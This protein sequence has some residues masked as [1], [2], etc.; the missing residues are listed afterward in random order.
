MRHDR[1]AWYTCVS[2]EIGLEVQVEMVL[3]CMQSKQKLSSVDC[4]FSLSSFFSLSSSIIAFITST[5][6]GNKH[7]YR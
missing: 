6:I 5:F 7:F 3:K 1:F 2:G 4:V